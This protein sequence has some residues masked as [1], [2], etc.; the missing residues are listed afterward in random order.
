MSK[1]IDIRPVTAADFTAWKP[2]WDGYNEFY[3]RIGPTALA[4]EI[5]AQTWSRFLD[6]AQPM[7]A[8]VA[9]LDGKLIGLT[10]YLYH[11]ST[12]QLGPSCYLQDLFTIEP[13]RGTGVGRKLIE[14]VYERAHA[15]GAARVYWQTHETNSTAMQLY[16]KIAEK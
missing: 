6:P 1:A 15:A 12:S 3:G 5:T 2:L 13:A 14:A 7:Q 11:L 10:H 4:P 8:L 16:D 9:E